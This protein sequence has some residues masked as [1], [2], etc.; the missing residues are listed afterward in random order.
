[1]L[2]PLAD[3]ASKYRVAVVMVTHLAKGSG[4]KAVYRAMG[5]LAFAAA[6][7]AVWHVAKDHD[8]DKRRLIL[9]AKIN[10]AVEATGLAAC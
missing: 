9:L 7:R 1:M 4:G 3:L 8:D 6:A 10:I 2:A 5:S